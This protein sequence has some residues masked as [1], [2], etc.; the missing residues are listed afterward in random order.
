MNN[1]EC[2]YTPQVSSNRCAIN[3]YLPMGLVLGK[4]D[5]V[6]EVPRCTVEVPGAEEK[7][8]SV[9]GERQS[10]GGNANKRDYL[11]GFHVGL[12]LRFPL[13]LGQRG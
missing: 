2:V 3:W 6:P 11:L 4:E 13:E 10:H 8:S 12:E 7:L 9:K 5:G 1:V